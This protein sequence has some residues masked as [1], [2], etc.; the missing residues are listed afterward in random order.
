MGPSCNNKTTVCKNV[1]TEIPVTVLF[2]GES[3]K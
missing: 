2:K 3:A 1:Y